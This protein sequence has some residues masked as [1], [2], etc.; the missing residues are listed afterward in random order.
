MDSNGL[1]FWMLSQKDDWPLAPGV[2]TQTLSLLGR[3]VDGLEGQIVLETAFVAPPPSFVLID[4]EVMSVQ[5]TDSTGL[6]LSVTRG[7]QDSVAAPHPKG[8]LIWRSVANLQKDIAKDDSQLTVTPAASVAIA[9][10]SIL[11]IGTEILVVNDVEGGGTILTVT[12]GAYGSVPAVYRAG[13]PLF[14][15]SSNALYYCNESNRLQLRSLRLGTAPIESSTEAVKLVETTPMAR[16]KFGNY[17]RW[18]SGNGIVVAG[19]SGPGEITIYSPPTGAIVTDLTMGYDGVLY[20]AVD[21]GLVM[22]DRQERWPNFS[23][24]DPSFNFWRLAALPGGGVLALD[25]SKPQ[26]GRVSGLPL[27]VGPVDQPNPGILRSC[28]ANPNPPQITA[29]YPLRSA[30]LP[31][32]TFVA[33]APVGEQFAL[34]S[35][36]SDPSSNTASYLRLFD[37]NTGL[38]NPYQLSDVVLP[39]AVAWLG[40]L[41]LAVL[42]TGLNEALV[43]DLAQPASTLNP[44]GT[45][46]V[47]SGVNSGPFAHT[48]SLPPYYAAVNNQ[49]LPLLPLSLNSLAAFG[50][51][52]LRPPKMVDSGRAKA[53]WHRLFLEAILPQ[54]TSVVVWL[55]ASDVPSDI[56]SPTAP[57][58]PHAFGDADMSVLTKDAP[59]GVW[60]SIPSEVPFAKPLLGEDI[61]P[62]RQGLFMVLVQRTNRAVRNLAGR[63]LGIRVELRGECRSTPE[64][65][66]LR[67]WGSRFSYVQNYLP[68]LYR[69][70]RFGPAADQQ[71][72]CT[73]HDFF[74]RFV[75]IFE[76]QLT[77]IEDRIANAYLLTRAESAPDDA[78]DWLGSWVGLNA[79]G[80]PPDRRRARLMASASLH[81]KRG[82]VQGITQALDIATN[83]LCSRGAVIVIEDFRLRHIFATILGADLDITNDPLLPGFNGTS[84]SFVGNTLFVGDPRDQAELLALFSA[85][86]GTADPTEVQQFYDSL[87]HRMTIFVHNQVDAVDLNLVQKIVDYEKPAHIA[88]T[89]RVATQPFLVGLAS[90]VR[91]DSYLA[92]Q[93][94]RDPVVIGTTQIGGFNRVT[95]APGLDP[96]LEI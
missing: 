84:N 85:P 79:T 45:T 5:A 86:H 39:Y 70:K 58:Y 3:E 88:A 71:G 13:A 72:S 43:F 30:A 29:K 59:Q 93:P 83:G 68:E 18:D 11:Q 4:A 1:N 75:N 6:Q 66:A 41:N 82:T 90:L 62:N 15:V 28:Q 32:E 23:L 52:D 22:I 50:T 35:W 51:T 19:G 34:L 14:S 54:R 21:G 8:A 55:T 12:R 91:V 76:A 16:D 77:R 48:Q 63:F 94:P 92:P 2:S 9:A 61:V 73:R 40:D 95:Q 20:I 56:S 67:V 69:E 87:A 78:L 31:S 46:Y 89:I 10:D 44:A 7:A 64:I 96:R 27:Q 26:L 17:A 36:K 33:I 74:E 37:F 42:A 60:L 53:V 24:T 57:W 65:A 25:R 47:L 49:L 38:G 81:R 80:Y